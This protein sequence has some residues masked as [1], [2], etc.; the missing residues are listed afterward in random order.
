MDLIRVDDRL[1]HGQVA[2][3][4]G[5]KINPAHMII[6]DDRIAAD[7][8][9]AELYLLGVPPG[10]TGAVVTVAGAKEYIDGIKKGPYIMV[11]RGINDALRLLDSGFEYRSLNIGGIHLTEGKREISHYIFLDQ[12]EIDVLKRIEERGVEVYFQDLPPNRKYSLKDILNKWNRYER[13]A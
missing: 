3:G 4:W 9:E 13:G 8:K 6:A 2:V 1:I 11:L 10:V 5:T 12:E 7:P